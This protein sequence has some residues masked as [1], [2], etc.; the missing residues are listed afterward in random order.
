MFNDYYWRALAVKFDLN[1][2]VGFSSSQLTGANTYNLTTNPGPLFTGYNQAIRSIPG[3]VV[4]GNITFPRTP[5]V[6]LFP[7]NIETSL[8]D[9]TKVRNFV[10]CQHISHDKTS[11]DIEVARE[12][13]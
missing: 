7:G 5:P 3:I 6:R 8:D 4:P 12:R 9:R 1:N 2:T 10:G 13:L 11:I